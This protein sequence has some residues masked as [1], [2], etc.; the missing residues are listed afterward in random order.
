MLDDSPATREGSFVTDLQG[1]EDS[2]VCRTIRAALLC[3]AC[4]PALAMCAQSQELSSDTI[5]LK[6]NVSPEGVPIIE[7]AVWQA[8]GATVFRDL[9]APNGLRDWISE[10]FIPATQ[11]TPPIWTIYER[12]DFPIAEATCALNNKLFMTFIV[13]LPKKGQLFRV[14]VR[15]TNG[16]KKTQTISTFPSW[17]ASWDVGGRTDWVRSWRSIEY[18]RVEQPL[19][20]EPVFIGSRLYSSD[21]TASGVNPYW[22]VG[23]SASRIYFGLE[24]C[25]GWSANLRSVDSGF[26]F[27]VGLP[28]AETQLEL[29]RGETIEGPALLVAPIPGSDD[30][31]ARSRW[32]LQRQAFGQS[33]YSTPV[34][35]Y[36]LTYNHWYAVR[37]QVNENFLNNQ[38]AAMLPY[39]FDAFVLDA[40][41]F[42]DGKWKPDPAK[43]DPGEFS[44]TLASLKASRIRPGLWSTPQYVSDTNNQSGLEIEDPPVSN[45]FLGG[46]LVDLSQE[47]F[48][49]YLADHVETLR[50]KYSMD[51]WKYDQPFFAEQSRSG[52]MKNVIGFQDALKNVRQENPDLFIENCQNGGRMINEFTLLATQTTWLKD[53]SLEAAPDPRDNISVALKAMDFVFPWAALRFTI[54]LDSMD[55][56][57]DEMLRLYCRS[58]MAGVWGISTDLTAVTD[59]QRN[60]VLTEIGNYRRLNS[61]KYSCEYDLRLPDD[62]ADVAGVTLYSRRRFHS[63]V[64]LYRWQRDGAFDQ[65]VLL[66]KLKSWLTYHVVDA[67]TGAEFTASGSE[68]ISNGINVPFSTKR[69]SALVFIQAVTKSQTAPGQ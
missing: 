52:L 22:V 50:R 31:D 25:G 27:G 69:L 28:S 55:S 68:L 59:R 65:K 66:P 8:T 6:L 9:G 62:S 46:N 17:F 32:M 67:D 39:S 5:R 63:A 49:S 41:W 1:R 10:A 38:L 30:T 34:P 19:N 44:Q 26:R 40:G 23:G 60:I 7:E 54:N 13:E 12:E 14:H 18:D 42:T 56:N 16:G 37:R 48:G 57:D 43:F 51:Y 15:L 20:G 24:W 58:A 3:F 61:L 33:I 21:D 11:I 36:P 45:R 29:E 2:T 4:I 64:L 53:L 35:S 47:E